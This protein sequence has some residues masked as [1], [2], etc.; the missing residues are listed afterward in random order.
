MY[1]LEGNI[2]VGKTTFLS[3]LPEYLPDLDIVPEPVDIW[4]RSVFGQSLLAN[5]YANPNRWAYTLETLT[6]I[7]RSQDHLREQKKTNHKRLLER[8]IYSGHYCFATTGFKNKCLSE[9]EWDI[10][11]KWVNFLIHKQCLP[12]RGFVYLK[13]TPETCFDR[14]QK[15]NRPAEESLT[16]KYLKQVDIVHDDFLVHK[17][18]LSKNLQQIPTLVLDCNEDFLHNPKNMRK[19][20]EKLSGFMQ[21]PR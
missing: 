1:F 3:L 10:Y 12:P 2:G 7:C 13:A 6:L 20:A 19:H 5:F 4:D 21:N 17:K 18:G 16:L 15:R 8:S 14:V 11:N 9:I